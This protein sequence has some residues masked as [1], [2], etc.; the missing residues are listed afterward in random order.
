MNNNNSSLL[1]FFQSLGLNEVKI[2]QKHWQ[3]KS[4]DSFPAVIRS[5]F[6]RGIVEQGKYGLSLH[7]FG[8]DFHFYLAISDYS[9]L[10]I[11]QEVDFADIEYI[12]IEKD[13]DRKLRVCLKGETRP[14]GE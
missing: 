9:K 5:L 7:I 8:E 12:V 6:K 14:F 11:N 2:Y 3:E 10:E 13:G 1:Q 4:R